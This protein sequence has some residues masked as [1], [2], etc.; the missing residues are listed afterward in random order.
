MMLHTIRL[1]TK[2]NQLQTMLSLEMSQL[3]KKK[4]FP[5]SQEKWNINKDFSKVLALSF[6][7][8]LSIKNEHSFKAHKNIDQAFHLRGPRENL[9]A[10]GG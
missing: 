9:P 6:I 7:G 3:K 4:I 1:A 2:L 5:P 8:N 10:Q